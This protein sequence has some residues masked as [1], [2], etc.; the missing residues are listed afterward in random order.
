MTWEPEDNLATAKEIVKEYYDSIGGRPDPPAGGKKRG[1]K[2]GSKRSFSEMTP[3]ST[4]SGR[5][6]KK[7]ANGDVSEEVIKVVS[8]KNKKKYPPVGKDWDD[9]LV[10]CETIEEGHVNAKGEREKHA[11]LVWDDGSKTRNPLRLAH[12]HAPQTVHSGHFL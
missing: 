4:T 10:S 6:R 5:G 8:T 9:V 3:E 11:L 12:K 7:R 1:P 2:K